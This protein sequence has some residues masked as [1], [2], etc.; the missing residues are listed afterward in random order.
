[1]LYRMFSSMPGLC[2]LDAGT[3]HPWCD[4]QNAFRYLP[5]TRGG[6]R[7]GPGKTKVTL[8]ENRHCSKMLPFPVFS[9]GPTPS[10]STVCSPLLSIELVFGLFWNHW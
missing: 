4:N 1:M 9:P 5:D 10:P 2:P 7:R 6:E 8:V 3:T